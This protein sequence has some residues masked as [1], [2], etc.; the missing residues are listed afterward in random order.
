MNSHENDAV[1]QNLLATRKKLLETLTHSSLMHDTNIKTLISTAQQDE[2]PSLLTSMIVNLKK[3]ENEVKTVEKTLSSAS[4]AYDAL[5]KSL[6]DNEKISEYK[7]KFFFTESQM[8][9]VSE[10]FR[11][12]MHL[13][14]AM[15]Y[16]IVIKKYDELK[17][18]PIAALNISNSSDLVRDFHENE[19]K[20]QTHLSKIIVEPLKNATLFLT[21]F[22]Q[23]MNDMKRVV[24]AWKAFP[25]LVEARTLK[26]HLDCATALIE[27]N[28]TKIDQTKADTQQMKPLYDEL[29]QINPEGKALANQAIS[30]INSVT[31]ASEAKK[32]SNGG[33]SQLGVLKHRSSVE[34]TN[35]T[36]NARVNSPTT[37]CAN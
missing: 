27:I 8:I 26:A 25:L 9:L 10:K 16:S 6:R 35:P 34:Q 23:M 28:K 7:T 12:F 19:I 13:K 2:L 14:Q 24:T 33:V 15:Q 22:D 4:A 17:A 1:L 32:A 3:A 31:Q 18:N 37:N 20:L 29:K 36:E 30:L 21:K 11:P 5:E